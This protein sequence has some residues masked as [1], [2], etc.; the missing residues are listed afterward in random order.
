VTDPA[1]QPLVA[2]ARSEARL[3]GVGLT[4]AR[5][6]RD[7]I[8][9][10]FREEVA[11]WADLDYG[12]EVRGDAVARRLTEPGAPPPDVLVVANPAHLA[13]A[14]LLEA[15]EQPYGDRYPAGWVE[16]NGAWAPLYVQPVVVV[17]NGHHVPVPPS[18]W[19]HMGDPGRAGKLVFEEPWAMLATGPA[20]AELSAVLGTAAWE[21]LLRGMAGGD[22]LIVA[23]NERSV[24]EVATGSRHTGLS[25]WNVAVRVRAASPV[26]HVFLDPTPCIPGFAAL[27]AGGS[28]PN[29]ARLF[30]AWLGS[31]GGQRAYAATGRIPA[32]PG[33]DAPTEMSRVL[34]SGVEPVFGAVDWLR[35]PEPW[36]ERYRATFKAPRAPLRRGKMGGF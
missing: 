34:P 4:D 27:P 33:I 25:N 21:E 1:L 12:Q 29:L 14:G 32:M 9:A 10:A 31:P 8:W 6:M 24:L 35:D 3:V 26:R 36:V 20:L 17:Y 18:R 22:P 28:S 11:P 23:D 15:H 5:S 7:V 16:A 13:A 30:L 19:E 2:A